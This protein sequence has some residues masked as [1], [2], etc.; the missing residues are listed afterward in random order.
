[1]VKMRGLRRRKSLRERK[2]WT[3]VESSTT[4]CRPR[5][6]RRMEAAREATKG[7]AAKGAAV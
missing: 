5:E 4:I 7:E 3:Q 1:M 2:A 6:K